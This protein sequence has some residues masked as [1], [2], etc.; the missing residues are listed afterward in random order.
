MVVGVGALKLVLWGGGFC[1]VLLGFPILTGCGPK[2]FGNVREGWLSWAD[3]PWENVLCC[4]IFIPLDFHRWNWC[5]IPIP[6][7]LEHSCAT[8]PRREEKNI[9][10]NG[11]VPCGRCFEQAT[12]LS[13]TYC[14]LLSQ[15][16]YVSFSLSSL[17]SRRNLG[18]GTYR[19]LFSR[20]CFLEGISVVYGWFESIFFTTVLSWERPVCWWCSD[21]L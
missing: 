20:D 15:K 8:M 6:A 19:S 21:L 3:L 1:M 2:C 7:S 14:I 16:P 4:F 18:L 17:I 9:L 12:R 10:R 11:H 5:N 13:K